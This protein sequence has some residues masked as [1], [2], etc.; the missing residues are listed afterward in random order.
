M[1][2]GGQT[3]AHSVTFLTAKGLFDW[4]RMRHSRSLSAQGPDQILVCSSWSLHYALIASGV[5]SATRVPCTKSKPIIQQKPPTLMQVLI[6]TICPSQTICVI[7]PM[8][9][10]F[11]HKATKTVSSLP[12]PTPCTLVKTSCPLPQQLDSWLVLLFLPSTPVVPN[13]LPSAS[14]YIC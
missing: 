9:R 14:V 11:R 7:T 10:C 2:G 6:P 5:C 1:K 13:F 3:S 8:Q 12:H 4:L